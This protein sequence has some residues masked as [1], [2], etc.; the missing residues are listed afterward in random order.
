MRN[1]LPSFLIAVSITVLV[2]MLWRRPDPHHEFIFQLLA[3]LSDDSANMG[4]SRGIT[5]EV[6]SLEHRTAAGN[7][8]RSSGLGV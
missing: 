5:S 7:R 4:S 6:R 8:H 3:N 2:A 1:W